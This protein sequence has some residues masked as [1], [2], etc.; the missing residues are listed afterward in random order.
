M[1]NKLGFEDHPR[2]REFVDKMKL[3][4]NHRHVF[5]ELDGIEVWENNNHI[6]VTGASALEMECA[7]PEAIKSQLESSENLI[8]EIMRGNDTRRYC[9]IYAKDP[10]WDWKKIV[11]E[12]ADLKIPAW[13]KRPSVG[14]NIQL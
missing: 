10:A 9:N 2:M 3:L 14:N 6:T 1:G 11:E 7:D 13:K 4:L 5:T 12:V 8:A